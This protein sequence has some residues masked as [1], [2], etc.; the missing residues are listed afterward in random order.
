MGT[1]EPR[2]VRRRTPT[3]AHAWVTIAKRM[4]STGGASRTKR[5]TWV[6]WVAPSWGPAARATPPK[7]FRLWR[8]GVQS[9]SPRIGRSFRHDSRDSPP[10]PRRGGAKRRGG[11]GQQI[12]FLT[13]TT[14]VEAR[15]AASTFPSSAEEGSDNL[16]PV[17]KPLAKFVAALILVA[18]VVS[19]AGAHDIP[20]DI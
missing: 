6:S 10:Q 18:V 20:N 17:P 15:F 8:G 7:R 14:P 16:A 11:V 9:T 12:D 1:L 3:A 5:R 13:S 4:W 19:T 2:W